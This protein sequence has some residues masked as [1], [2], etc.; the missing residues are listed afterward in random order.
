VTQ[1]AR[2]RYQVFTGLAVALVLL[3]SGMSGVVSMALAATL[4]VI[5][6]LL[7]PEIRG[8]AII[9]A[10]IAVGVAVATVAL[11]RGGS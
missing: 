6:L 1:S 10:A 4:L 11:S 8:R 3:T 7:Y 2:L 5:G 9:A